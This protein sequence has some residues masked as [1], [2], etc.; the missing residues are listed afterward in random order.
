MPP[1]LQ[2]L[3][4][5]GWTCDFVVRTEES[6]ALTAIRTKKAE[7]PALKQPALAKY[8]GEHN[9]IGREACRFM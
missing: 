8:C 4:L 2:K 7:M 5:G 3:T 9:D 6:T 1:C